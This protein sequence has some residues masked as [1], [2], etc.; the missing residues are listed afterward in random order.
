M[1]T[2]TSG[3]TSLRGF[4]L[5]LLLLYLFLTSLKKKNHL[6]KV[7]TQDKTVIEVYFLLLH[8]GFNMR[9]AMFI[10]AQ[11]GHETANFKSKIFKENNNCFG[12]K[13]ALIR[14]TTAT[15]EKYGHA[16]YKTLKDCIDD[17]Y[18]YYLSFK[19]LKEYKNISDY[20]AA[21]KKRDYFTAS[22][23][24]YLAGCEYWF[25]KYFSVEETQGN[26]T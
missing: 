26:V 22:E 9:Q 17:F 2:L 7:I 11:A 3:H 5:F 15:G 8:K 19:Y 18:L 1:T 25:S 13:L 10:T 23:Y 24:E 14:K 16:T 6:S 21:L 20:V 12:M 4:L